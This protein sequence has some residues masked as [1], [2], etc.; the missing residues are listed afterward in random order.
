MEGGASSSDIPDVTEE[1]MV[2]NCGDTK[3]ALTHRKLL[4]DQAFYDMELSL[5]GHHRKAAPVRAH[6]A[7]LQIRVPSLLQEGKFIGKIE[8]NKHGG[9]LPTFQRRRCRTCRLLC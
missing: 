4:S 7:V 1:I 3:L 9:R 6:R 2:F 5:G 8:R